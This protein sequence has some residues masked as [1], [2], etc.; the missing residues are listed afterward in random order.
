[1]AENV[2]SFIALI[3]MCFVNKM[4]SYFGDYCLFDI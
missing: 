4:S 3:S 2:K 1:M